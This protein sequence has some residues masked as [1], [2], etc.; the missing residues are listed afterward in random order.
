MQLIPVKLTAGSEVDIP[1]N[2]DFIRIMSAVD[3]VSIK[4]DTGNVLKGMAQGLAWKS[5]KNFKKIWLLSDTTQ[6][7]EVMV[8]FGDIRDDRLTVS[9]TL[10]TTSKGATLSNAAH[11]VGLAAAELLA[12]DI[13]RRSV[14]INNEDAANA[15]Y[16]GSDAT[17]TAATGLRVPAGQSL[18]LSYAA[19]AAIYAI[20]A[21]AGITVKTL[22]ELD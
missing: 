2:G 21:A 10:D 20:G 3:S 16:I 17:V 5:D 9:T 15:I 14:I 18:A 13:T 11:T 19:G 7:I 8:G 12:A 6:T 22:A 1:A 4:A